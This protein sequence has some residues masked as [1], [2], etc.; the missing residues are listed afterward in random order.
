MKINLNAAFTC[1]AS[2]SF[3]FLTFFRKLSSRNC[4]ALTPASDISKADS[5]SSYSSSP[6]FAPT[7]SVVRLEDVLARP[8]LSRISQPFFFSVVTTAA[9]IWV[10]VSNVS[11]ELAISAAAGALAVLKNDISGLEVA[12]VDDSGNVAGVGVPGREVDAVDFTTGEV[13]AGDVGERADSPVR[14]SVGDV[15]PATTSGISLGFFLKKLNIDNL[16]AYV[17]SCVK[18]AVLLHCVDRVLAE[19]AKLANQPSMIFVILTEPLSKT[20]LDLSLLWTCLA[21]IVV[22]NCYRFS[23]VFFQIMPW[24]C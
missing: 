4:V 20:P 15:D 21:S 22:A 10:S 12:G 8:D 5:S 9:T 3:S 13:T 16:E 7:K 23:I 17:V 24:A 19:R 18:N 1:I 6:I 11:S 2:V 14:S